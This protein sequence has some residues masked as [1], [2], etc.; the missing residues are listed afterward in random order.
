MNK[1]KQIDILAI[2]DVAIDVFIKIID[3]EAKCDLEG[4]HCKLCVSYGGKIPYE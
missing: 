4:E 3:A 1:D 2:G